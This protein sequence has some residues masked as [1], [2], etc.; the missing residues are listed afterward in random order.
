[1]PII[2]DV[3]LLCYNAELAHAASFSIGRYFSDPAVKVEY[4]KWL[5]ERHKKQETE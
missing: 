1:M 2:T 3:D 5:K 4:E